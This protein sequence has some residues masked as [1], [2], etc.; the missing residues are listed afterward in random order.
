MNPVYFKY[1]GNYTSLSNWELA[2]MPKLPKRQT[3]TPK[4]NNKSKRY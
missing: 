2:D 3:Y 1:F 4:L